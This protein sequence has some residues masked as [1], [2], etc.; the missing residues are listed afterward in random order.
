MSGGRIPF[1][2]AEEVHAAL[3]LGALVGA[4]WEAFRRGAE[5]P[6]RH[7]HALD[8]G[9]LLLMPAWER[10]GPAGVKLATVFP[11]NGARGLPTVSALYVLLDER[12]QPRAVLD[13]EALTLRRTGAAS[14]LAAGYLAR[15]ESKVLLV[16][17]TGRLAPWMARAHAAVCSFEKVLV[18]GRAWEKA[19]LTAA[20]LAR[21]GLPARAAPDL[22]E[23]LSEADV[24]TAAT[25]SR[26]PLLLASQ[27]RPGTHLDL[28]GGFTPE[29]READD[30]LVARASLFVDTREGALAEAGDLV[31]PISR[32]LLQPAA[33]RADL[34]DLCAERHPG[35][36]SLGE[37]TLF[38]SVGTG[39]EDLAAARLAVGG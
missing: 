35:R 21:D 15:P 6:L 33:V 3:P 26:E 31:Q 13:G 29:M 1:L 8:G 24:V 32:G 28:V 2:T 18:W 27:V 14:A 10:G 4:L 20:E 17:G 38:K 11:E 22:A 16:V 30:A 39:L 23:A 9:R 19:V 5:V 34:A 37:I 36:R 7:V 25:T 12:G